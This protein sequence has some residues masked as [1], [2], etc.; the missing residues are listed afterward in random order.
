MLTTDFKKTPAY[1]FGF[2]DEKG[3][4]IKFLPDPNNPQQLLPNEPITRDEKNSLTPLHRLVFN[5]KK[6]IR[7][8]PFGK[9]AFASYA[10][11]LALLKEQTNLDSEQTDQL[12]EDFYRHLKDVDAFE[13]DMLT[14]SADVGQ[15]IQKD[16]YYL[17]RILKQNFDENGEMKVYKEKSVVTNVKQNSIGYGI[18]IYEGRIGDD[19]ILF[20]AEDV[21]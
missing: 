1:K 10:V 11:A 8:V 9:T 20:T 3:K 4:R 21:Y 13:S 7:L 6:L 16:E 17:R 19:R 18:L 2:I 14:E 5:L 12:F 15:I